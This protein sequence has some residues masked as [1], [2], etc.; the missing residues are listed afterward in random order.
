MQIF[1][2]PNIGPATNGARAIEKKVLSSELWNFGGGDLSEEMLSYEPALN[3][4]GRSFWKIIGDENL[5]GDLERCQ[6]LLAKLQHLRFV[7]FAIFSG[8]YGTIYL[9]IRNTPKQS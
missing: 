5:L 9:Q 2:S 3:F 4:S 6:I 8:N 1:P 7:Y